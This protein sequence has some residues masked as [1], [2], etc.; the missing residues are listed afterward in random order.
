MMDTSGSP[1][2]LTCSGEGQWAFP[3]SRMRESEH[4]LWARHMGLG[5]DLD[6]DTEPKNRAVLSKRIWTGWGFREV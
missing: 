1:P 4:P 3:S 6:E 2:D 5:S